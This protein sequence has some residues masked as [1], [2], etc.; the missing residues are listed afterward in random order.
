MCLC[1]MKICDEN[2]NIDVV[3]VFLVSGVRWVERKFALISIRL[4]SVLIGSNAKDKS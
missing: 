2:N 4:M 3:V 1:V